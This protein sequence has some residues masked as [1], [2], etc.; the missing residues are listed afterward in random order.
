VY[1]GGLLL[2][3]FRGTNGTLYA[4]K[5]AGPGTTVER[6]EVNGAPGAWLAGRPH[7]F[8]YVDARGR[9]QTET[10]RRATTRSCGSAAS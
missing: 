3:Q 5:V 8:V 2:T 10:L 4:G 9:T 6:T 1:P 7:A